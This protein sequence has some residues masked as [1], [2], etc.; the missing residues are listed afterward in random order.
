MRRLIAA[1]TLLLLPASAAAADDGPSFDCGKAA[2]RVE[3]AICADRIL[4]GYDRDLAAIYGALRAALDDQGKAALKSGQRAWL[5]GERNACE[6]SKATADL[7]AEEARIFCLRAAYEGRLV[8]LA[9]LLEQALDGAAPG[10]GWSGDY[11]YDDGNSAGDLR[12]LRLPEGFAFQILTVSGPTAHL[13]DIAGVEMEEGP[14]LLFWRDPDAGQCSITFA[15][16]EAGIAVTSTACQ[17]LC[18]ARGTFDATYT[19]R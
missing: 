19:R 1:L 14:D 2:S 18:G 12:L 9:E 17:D 15:R 4:A 3:K 6:A 10:A 7:T 13:C 16:G 8:R 11:G 5:T